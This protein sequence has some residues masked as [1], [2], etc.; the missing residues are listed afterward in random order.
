MPPVAAPAGTNDILPAPA[1]L[2]E[3]VPVPVHA[4]FSQALLTRQSKEENNLNRPADV[5]G[6]RKTTGFRFG[7]TRKSPII[8]EKY[9]FSLGN[10]RRIGESTAELRPEWRPQ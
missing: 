9:I 6:T 1:P 5:I 4:G 2:R 7:F 8:R 3:A 10:C